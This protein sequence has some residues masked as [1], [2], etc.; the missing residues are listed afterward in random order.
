[1]DREKDKNEQ[2]LMSIVSYLYYYADMNQADIA[3]RLFLSRSTVSRLL[4]KAQQSGVVELKIN[5]PWQRDLPMEDEIRT[6]FPVSRVRVL[7]VDAIAPAD[8]LDTLGH[9]ASFYI[10]CT[11]HSHSVLG[12]S[13]GNTIAHV[14][15]SITSSKNIPF[16]VVPIMGSM[17]WP[18]SNPESLEMSYR[19]SRIYGGRYF[20][21]DAP[22]YAPSKEEFGQLMSKPG[23]SE[24]LETARSADF[25]LTSVGSIRSRS[26]ENVIG[27]QKLSR[28]YEIGCVGHIGGHFFD[29]GG[30]EIDGDYK[31]LLIGL[32]L[33]EIRNS[34]D[35]ICVAASE[36]KAESVYGALRGGLVDTL[37]ITHPLGAKLLEI[38]NNRRL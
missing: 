16:T 31:E 37:M 22:L 8:V 21:L 33:D 29:I 20:P 2:E 28:L 9:M 23:I 34:R 10:S 5:E 25:I 3:D 4:K 26:W 1:M 19:F 11:A 18:N 6:A 12:M 13:W 15:D 36:Q 14:V 32:T 30:S 27:P 7:R 24:A 38:T 17:L 35:V